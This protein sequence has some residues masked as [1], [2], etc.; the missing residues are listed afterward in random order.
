MP[1][2]R[3]KNIAAPPYMMPIFLWSTV[4]SHDR[5][6]VVVTGRRNTPYDDAGVTNCGA[7][8]PTM[9]GTVEGRSMMAIWDLPYFRS[10]R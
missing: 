6:P 4:N 9:A 10:S 5:Q 3:K 2:T 8:P 7:S 1:P